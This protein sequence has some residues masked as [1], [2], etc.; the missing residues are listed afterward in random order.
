[1]RS[2][3]KR[4]AARRSKGEVEIQNGSEGKQSE[5]FLVGG[6]GQRQP[7]RP[8]YVGCAVEIICSIPQHW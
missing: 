7:S 2:S 3:V 4:E 1:M 5:P 8:R 6:F